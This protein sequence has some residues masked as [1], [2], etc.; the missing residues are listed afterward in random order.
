[1]RKLFILVAGV[2]LAVGSL[3]LNL[4]NA[5]GSPSEP[6]LEMVTWEAGSAPNHDLVLGDIKDRQDRV[7]AAHVF[8][9]DERF[10]ISD[11]TGSGWRTI[12]LLLFYDQSEEL[13][14]ECSG[15]FLNYNVVLTAAHCI[16]SDGEYAYSVVAAPGASEDAPEFGLAD[17]AFL[18][19]P[20]GW[21]DGPGEDP[22]GVPATPSQF[23]W[24]IVVF[25]GDPFGGQLGPYAFMAHAEDEFFNAPSTFIGTAGFPGDKPFGSMWAAES[26]E[27]FVDETYLYTLMDIYPGQSGSPIFAIDDT[28]FFI[29]SVVSLGGPVANLSVRF[30]PPVLNALEEYCEELG[31]TVNTFTWVPDET[32][33]PSPTPTATPTST[34]TPTTTPLPTLPPSPTP[35]AQPTSTPAGPAS[36]RP[37]RGVVPQLSRD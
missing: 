2:G 24:G 36:N 16:Y 21:A 35:T 25:E 15:V 22:P 19:V 5:A 29:F 14:G 33:V 8:P 12:T 17:A 7:G 1:M 27:Y 30:T 13:V 34:P 9:P 37:F 26:L 6:G 32:P 3:S 10:R 23:D 4:Q 28:D 11:S 20:N 31:C 18:A